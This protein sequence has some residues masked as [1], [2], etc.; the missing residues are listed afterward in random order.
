MSTVITRWTS[1]LAIRESLLKAARARLRNTKTLAN[2]VAVKLRKEQVAAAE[3]VIARHKNYAPPVAKVE[4]IPK[5]LWHPRATVNRYFSAGSFTGGG[6]KIVWHTTET[7]GLPAYSGS[8]PHFTFNPKTNE[9]WQHIPI[10]EAAKSLEHHDAAE[11][12]K[13]DGIQVELIGFASETGTWPASYYRNI[14][15]LARWIEYNAGVPRRCS[16]KFA[17][18]ATRL[19]DTEFVNYAGH[20]GHEHVPQQRA[21]H[22]DPGAFRIAEVL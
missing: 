13:A 21:G 22:W 10:N 19:S 17:V 18:P 3:R 12:N 5:V 2:L 11:T 9:M 7:H 16:V 4:D 15:A 20:L 1:R 14:A 8:A 6:K